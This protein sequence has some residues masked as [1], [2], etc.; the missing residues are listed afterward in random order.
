MGAA[1][2]QANDKIVLGMNWLAKV[3][4]GGYVAL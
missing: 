2:A 4:P 3:E 1:S